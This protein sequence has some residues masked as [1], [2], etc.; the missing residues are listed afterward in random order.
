MM[1]NNI[2]FGNS[3]GDYNIQELETALERQQAVG[4]LF[5]TVP[6]PRMM[7]QFG[8]LGYGYGDSGEQCL[9][10][11]NCPASAP[12]RTDRKPIRWDYR[13]PAQ[14]PNRVKLYET[15]SA[16]I[17]L[18][19]DNEVFSSTDTQVDLQVGSGELIKR[20]GLSHSTMDAIVIGNYDVVQRE[21]AVNF[22]SAGVWYDF[23]SGQELNIEAFEQNATTT[24][25][26]GEFHIFTS[27]PVT[28]PTSGLVAFG[29]GAPAPGAPTDLQTAANNQASTVDLSWTPSAAED[30]VS[31]QIYRSTSASFDTTGTLLTTVGASASSYTDTDVVLGPTYYYTVVATDNDG[32]RST[33]AG[34]ASASLYPE[35]IGVDVSRSFGQGSRQQ[36]YRLVALPGELQLSVDATFGG[37]AGE[38]WQVY[39]DDGSDENFL[40]E[41]D[42][43]ATFPSRLDADSGRSRLRR[44][45]CS[46]TFRP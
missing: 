32:A 4:A 38:D 12:G 14:S 39:W 2:A 30:V 28:F 19:M 44:G 42:G 33:T 9:R 23:F 21:V 35:Q 29:T 25:A 16:M 41:F 8:E 26:P 10:E 40:R 45:A 11:A 7:W 1:Y 13:D 5:F 37:T 15:W 46:A 34:T 31:H 6:G 36:D 43:S 17:N 3:S 27:E 18:R 24:M 20:V 22:P